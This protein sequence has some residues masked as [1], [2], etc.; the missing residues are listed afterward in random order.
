MT[1]ARFCLLALLLAAC[2]AS[3]AFAQA[4]VAGNWELT[5]VSPQG[6]NT[7]KVSFKQDGEKVMGMF[8][9]PAGELPLEGTLIG[10]DVKLAFSIN[11]QGQ[12][13]PITLTGKLEG[14][15]MAGKA[16]FGGFAEGDFSAKRS[17]E[18]ETAAA[19]PPAPP[20]PPAAAGSTPAASMGG[21]SGTWEI[22]LKT[23]GGDFPVSASLTDEAGK[24]S[25]T[26]TS[27]MGEVPVTGTMEGK[28][29]KLSLTANTPQGDIPI[30]LT[31]DLAGDEIL[32]G[33]ADFGGMGQGEWTAKRKQ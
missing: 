20:A 5:I 26:L 25:G 15:T 14:E 30:V 19:A 28:A 2:S 32:N 10:N 12:P 16:D 13:L 7:Q 1:R 6:P 27:Q 18:T 31:G 33:K 8:K 29:L 17:T 3:P 22:L 23:G 24:I 4:T 11:F 9:S 21:A